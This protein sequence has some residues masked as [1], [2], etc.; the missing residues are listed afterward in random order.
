MNPSTLA[1]ERRGHVTIITIDRPEVRNALDLP[2]Q[3][4]LAAVFDAF[5]ADDE[6]WIAILTGAGS[7]AFCAGFDLRTPAPGGPEDMP[8]SGFG[9]ITARFDLDKPVIA[10]V[11]G[12]AAGGGFEMALACDIVVAASYATFTLPEVKVGLIALGG[13]ILRLTRLIGMQHALGVALT[14]RRV[15]AQEG[16]RMGFVTEVTGPDETALDAALRWADAL[17]AV[18]PL[19]VRATKA[20][21]RRC[22]DEPVESAMSRQWTL[23]AVRRAQDSRDAREGPL[24]FIERRAPRWTGR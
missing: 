13:G 20:V 11:N 16:E 14:G 12:V 8:P 5:A 9:G 6:Q 24:A 17:L 22:L 7:L 15:S 3:F 18:A 4:A 2:T 21:A 19:A 23:A 1:V 10:A